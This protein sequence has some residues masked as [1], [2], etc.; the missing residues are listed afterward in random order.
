MVHC[1]VH[2]SPPLRLMNPVH[3]RPSNVAKLLINIFLSTMLR[4]S[5]LSLYYRLSANYVP[6][7][8]LPTYLII[9]DFIILISGRRIG[10]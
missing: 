6:S 7:F 2:K 9:L 4:A 8:H 5:K 10:K 1:R 3:V